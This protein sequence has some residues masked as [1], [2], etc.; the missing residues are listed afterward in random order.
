MLGNRVKIVTVKVQHYERC[1][2]DIMCTFV[3]SLNE[4][5]N[6][7]FSTKDIPVSV[8]RK[9]MTWTEKNKT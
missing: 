9:G 4:R 8:K 1:G 2:V 7:H 3:T 5:E 6:A